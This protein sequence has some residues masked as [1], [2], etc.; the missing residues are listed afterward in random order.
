MLHNTTDN[1][2]NPI[3]RQILSG[4]GAEYTDEKI[5]RKLARYSKYE[6]HYMYIWLENHKTVAIC[7]VEICDEYVFIH[8]LYVD[9]ISRRRGIGSQIIREVQV[10]YKLPIKAESDDDAVGFYRKVGF[11][12]SVAPPKHGTRHWALYKEKI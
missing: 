8:D 10:L 5:D 4:I 12:I 1:I 9:E 7:G 2:N 3:I 11:E 6:T